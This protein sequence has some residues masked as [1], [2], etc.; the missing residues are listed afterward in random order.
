M[1]PAANI[2]AKQWHLRISVTLQCYPPVETNMLARW[3]PRA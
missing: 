1:Q 2:D 3:F